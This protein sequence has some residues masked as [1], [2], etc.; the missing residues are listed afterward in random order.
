VLDLEHA[1]GNNALDHVEL[2]ID[3]ETE[4]HKV[5]QSAPT[6]MKEEETHTVPT[7]LLIETSSRDNEGESLELTILLLHGESE[8]SGFVVQTHDEGRIVT[9]GRQDLN[10]ELEV[11]FGP[12]TD[13]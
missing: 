6:I 12:G 13:C 2:A 9:L 4:G 8:D 7:I 10:I 3:Q 1:V 5:L 11:G